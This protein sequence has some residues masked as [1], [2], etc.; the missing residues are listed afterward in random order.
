MNVIQTPEGS[1]RCL[2]GKRPLLTECFSNSPA[3]EAS[4]S[5]QTELCNGRQETVGQVQAEGF[6]RVTHDLESKG[7]NPEAEREKRSADG[8]P[9]CGAPSPSL[10]L[11][12]SKKRL[13]YKSYKGTHSPMQINLCHLTRTTKI[14]LWNCPTTRCQHFMRQHSGKC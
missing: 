12:R 5:T 1:L 2:P 10:G 4:S 14:S 8:Q 6:G 13:P 11:A 7:S 3:Q 9:A